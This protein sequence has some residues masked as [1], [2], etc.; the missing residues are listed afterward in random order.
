MGCREEIR[1]NPMLRAALNIFEPLTKA[2]N[3]DEVRER[4]IG[5]LVYQISRPVR[6]IHFRASTGRQYELTLFHSMVL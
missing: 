2:V 1:E 4:V 3:K 6:T 5:Q